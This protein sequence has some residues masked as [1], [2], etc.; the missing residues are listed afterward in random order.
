[1]LK[2]N[3]RTWYHLSNSRIGYL[4]KLQGAID[5]IDV[6]D[7]LEPDCTIPFL[8]LAH[9]AYFY[10]GSFQKPCFASQGW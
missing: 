1:M 4:G 3:C 7:T 6:I 8:L 10:H 2:E 5:T 9:S